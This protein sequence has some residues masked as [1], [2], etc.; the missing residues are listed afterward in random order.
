MKHLIYDLKPY[1][2]QTKKLSAIFERRELKNLL[3]IFD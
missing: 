1:F 3:K 2:L